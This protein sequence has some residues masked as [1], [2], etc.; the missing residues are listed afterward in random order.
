MVN[1]LLSAEMLAL[2]TIIGCLER[3]SQLRASQ[4]HCQLRVLS[5]GEV[6]RCISSTPTS[7]NKKEMKLWIMLYKTCLI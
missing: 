3:G 6:S 5:S 1:P 7:K 2:T 4:Q